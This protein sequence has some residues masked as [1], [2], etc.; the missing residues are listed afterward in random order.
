MARIYLLDDHPVV[1]TGLHALLENAGHTILGEAE[2]ITQALADLKRLEPDVLVLDMHLDGRSGLE[3]LAE[4]Q[5]RQGLTKVVVLSM[6][7]R[8]YD[9][10]ESLRRGA[11]AYVL[12]TAPGAEL[13]AAIDAVV[14]GRRHLGAH[15]TDIALQGFTGDAQ[16]DAPLAPRERQILAMVASGLSSAAIGKELHLSPKTVD[17]YRSRLMARLELADLPALVR[18]A[19]REKLI[20]L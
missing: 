16:P 19:V 7:D 14:Q 17:T 18:W 3:V 15:L 6:S 12:K 11:A 5:R 2:D 13:L 1:R 20:E 8:K 10:T 9:V 4:L